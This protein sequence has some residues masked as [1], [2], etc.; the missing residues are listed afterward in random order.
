MVYTV[1]MPGKPPER[2][3]TDFRVRPVDALVVCGIAVFRAVLVRAFV[4]LPMKSVHKN[5]LT[6]KI[7]K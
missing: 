6:H 3:L 5:E 4:V 2:L 1:L 7:S